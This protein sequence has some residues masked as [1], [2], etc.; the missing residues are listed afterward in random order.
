MRKTGLWALGVAGILAVY[1]WAINRNTMEMTTRQKILRAVYPLFT[2][3]QKLAGAHARAHLPAGKT[4]P[5]VSIYDLSVKLIDG[6]TK[7][8]SDFRGRKILLVNTASD[9]G[10]TAQYEGLQELS[11]TYPQKLVVIGFP[12][13]DF[14]EQEKGDDAEIASF[15]KRNF[16]VSFPL[17]SKASVIKGPDQ[18]PVFRWL[19]DAGLNGWN[20]RAPVWN[21]SKYLVDE[22]GRLAG[23]F[24]PAVDPMGEEIRRAVLG[25]K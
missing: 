7:S 24:E 9:C 13:N 12:A 17:A 2:T 15:C 4:K 6:T 11:D 19:T 21:F 14:K 23:V 3:V 25:D 5:P 20:K 22:E 8:L 1:V 16:G 18:H 10:Y